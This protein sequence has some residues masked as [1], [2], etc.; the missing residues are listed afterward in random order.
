MGNPR[1]NYIDRLKGIAILA[2]VVG[3]ISFF[4]FH[5]F[6]AVVGN[7][8]S[9]FHMAIFIFLSG[10][11]ISPSH[12]R[13]LRKDSRFLWPM[14]VVG[15][16]FTVFSKKPIIGFFF[17]AMK[18]G[19]W[20]LFVLSIFYLFVS[21]FPKKY[22]EGKIRSKIVYIDFLG[23]FSIFILF[24][25]LRI[26]FPSEVNSL[27]S[28]GLCSMYWPLF[29][30]GY[31]ARKYNLIDFL[32][33]KDWIFSISFILYIITCTIYVMGNLHAHMIASLFSVPVFVYLFKEREHSNTLIEK[34]LAVIGKNSLEIYLFHYFFL[35]SLHLST[36]GEWIEKSDNDLIEF[37]VGLVFAVI[38]AYVCILAGYVIKR[39][40]LLSMIIY[41]NT[42]R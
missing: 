3:H 38:C 39:S 18:G 8:V 24:V 5:H 36:F 32:M 17:D 2:V 40:K 10:L 28:I 33:E 35:R 9:S 15:L 1:I 19:Y 26:I 29:I 21:F 25:G 30:G 23:A 41:G 6:E 27:F 14:L 22:E 7:F 11:M 20:Y 16:L 42:M 13:S 12:K 31:L 37:I 4:S 34:Q